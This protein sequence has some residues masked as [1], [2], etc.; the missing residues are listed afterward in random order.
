MLVCTVNWQ[1]KS[2][3]GKRPRATVPLLR[4]DAGVARLFF[5]F[6]FFCLWWT[7]VVILSDKQR[8]YMH[9]FFDQDKALG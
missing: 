2:A 5:H 8:R 7:D 9:G 6:S 3:A 4:E 1:C